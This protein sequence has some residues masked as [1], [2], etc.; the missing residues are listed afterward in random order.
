MYV[1]CWDGS[2][3]RSIRYLPFTFIV[4]VALKQV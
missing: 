1:I 3:I 4:I 2:D